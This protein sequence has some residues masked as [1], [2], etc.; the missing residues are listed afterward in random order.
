MEKE[1]IIFF[2]SENDKKNENE[3]NIIDLSNYINENQYI[4]QHE[5]YD[6]L[7]DIE[8]LELYYKEFNVKTIT[9][10]LQYYGI[11]KSK[12][13]KDEMIQ[14]L[15]FFETDKNNHDIVFRRVRLWKNIQELKDD[16][17]FSKYI[18]F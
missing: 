18:M 8:E 5:I 2:L 9:Q 13:I 7:Y 16:S 15:L 17:Y 10:I 11:Y 1:N 4:E 12:M 3:N 6:K 14:V